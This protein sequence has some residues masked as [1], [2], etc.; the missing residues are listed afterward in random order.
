MITTLIVLAWIAVLWPVPGYVGRAVEQ[1][2]SRLRQ[3]TL[4]DADLAKQFMAEVDFL[5]MTGGWADV[6]DKHV[7]ELR[8]WRATAEQCMNSCHE[9]DAAEVARRGLMILDRLR[10]SDIVGR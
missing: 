8:Q 3:E 7:I 9:A 2:N 4:A 6:C 5:D 10:P 1:W